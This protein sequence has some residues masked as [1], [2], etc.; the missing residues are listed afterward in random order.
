MRPKWKCRFWLLVERFA[1]RL[2]MY[3]ARR[4]RYQLSEMEGNVAWDDGLGQL[5]E[6]YGNRKHL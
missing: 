2:S 1:N 4:V 3:S 5:W 6:L